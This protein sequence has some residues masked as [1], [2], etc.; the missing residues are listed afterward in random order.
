M[1]RRSEAEQP[2]RHAS[3]GR[4][5]HQAGTGRHWRLLHRVSLSIKDTTASDLLGDITWGTFA[6]TLETHVRSPG[7][8]YPR[9]SHDT[10]RMSPEDT[11]V[12]DGD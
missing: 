3:Q 12:T 11:G 1:K 5:Q 8:A 7:S 10:Q 4:G 6:K 2:L 9:P